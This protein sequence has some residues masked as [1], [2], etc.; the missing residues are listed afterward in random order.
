MTTGVG[1][2]VIG[3]WLLVI[4]GRALALHAGLKSRF[5]KT[6]LQ[7][8]APKFSILNSQ[9]SI[10]YRLLVTRYSLLVSTIRFLIPHSSFLIL[11]GVR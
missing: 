11:R 2:L 7:R 9:F 3:Y 8:N 6:A 5:K 4:G 10:N 1:L